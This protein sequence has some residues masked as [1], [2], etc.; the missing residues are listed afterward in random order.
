M[1]KG[2]TSLR[3]GVSCSPEGLT[4][5]IQAAQATIVEES[6]TTH[7]TTGH[8]VERMRSKTNLT[9]SVSLSEKE[10]KEARQR[11]HIIAAQLTVPSSSS[12]RGVQLFNR[13]KQRV[14]AFTLES[15]GVRSKEDVTGNVKPNPSC[16]KLTWAERSREEKDKDL[17]YKNCTTNPLFVPIGST[18]ATGDSMEEQGDCYV[19]EDVAEHNTIQER[20]FLPVKEIDEQEEEQKDAVYKELEGKVKDELPPERE[21]T[22]PIAMNLLE[23]EAAINVGHISSPPLEKLSNGC[24]G[25]PITG[26]SASKQTT[27]INRTA[28]PF[29]SPLT[30]QSQEADSPVLDNLPTRFAF[31]APQPV[32][33]SPPP[34]P[35]YPTPP[36]P[37]FTNKPPKTDYFSPRVTTP[38][39]PPPTPAFTVSQN[40]ATPLPRYGPPTAPKPSA[41]VPQP[42]PERKS[43]PPIKTGLLEDFA[44]KRP[45]KKSMF[46]FKEKKV[47][48]PNPEL[49]SLVQGVDEM[50]NHRQRSVP[51]SASEEELLALGAEA[52]NFLA[53]EEERAEEAN[54][55]E[56]TSCLKS[57]RTYTRVELKPEQTLG[58]ASGKGADLFAKR[59]SRME[60]FIVEN[61][62]AGQHIRPPSPTMSLPPSWVYPSN[63]PGRVKAIAK[64]SDMCAQLA[65]NM[66]AQQTARSKP[67]QAAPAA[68]VQETL[69]LENG[70]S[71]TEM[72]LSRH[73]PYQLN[74]SLFILKPVKDPLNTLPKGA[75]QSKNEFLPPSLSRQAS[76]PNNPASLFSTQSQSPQFPGSSI[77]RV[78]YPSKPAGGKPSTAFSPT[79]VSSPRLGI[80]APKPR[81][82]AKKAGLEAQKPKE[83]SPTEPPSETRLGPTRKYS[84]PDCL[85]TTWMSGLQTKSPS[86][87]V[88]SRSVASPIP[89]ST[90]ARCQS[91]M[92]NQGIQL[93][94]VSLAS[95][96]EPPQTS[97]STSPSSPPWGSR[98]HSPMVSQNIQSSAN[99]SSHDFRFQTS[100][101]S[102]SLPWGSRCQSP[103]VH[104]QSSNALH[105]SSK[106]S[107]N[108]SPLSPPWGSRC[109]SPM[110]SVSAENSTLPSL[111]SSR[112]FQTSATA[113]H[114]SPP[115]S[116]RCQSPMVIQ[117]IHPS[118]ISTSTLSKTSTS[119]SLVSPPWRSRSQS[120]ALSHTSLSFPSANRL[121]ISSASFPVSRPKDSRC[122][123]PISNN[124]DSKANH[125]MLAKNIINAAKRK[126]SPSPGALGGH[127][128]PISPVGYAL[129]GYN[130][131]PVQSQPLGVQSPTFTSPPPTPT[132]RI[133]SPVRLYN[134][135]SLT[136]SDASIESEDSGLR[137][138]G[139]HSYNTCPRGWSGSLRVK[140]ST[141]STDL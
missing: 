133:C 32:A 84:S 11:S 114:R 117:T 22:N 30:V 58:D 31:T 85:G 103:V 77:T 124:L 44:A 100:N 120:P 74:S 130:C 18:Q 101:S 87:R 86:A 82:S 113:P 7:E 40:A 4:K 47:V 48:A 91:P 61:Q 139:M 21:N 35:A 104:A 8:N 10:L 33:V 140:K 56:W 17:N 129:H 3:R 79:H 105:I 34:P 98:C 54:A 50:K 6:N 108:T 41:F 109:Q 121:S 43:V 5:P 78:D 92:S 16:G 14:S 131:K 138:P 136:D 88:S 107:T 71:K 65:L 64:N 127:S 111:S 12:S 72:D 73:R 122:M 45:T 70:C 1:E 99:S 55:P 52:S 123:S 53:K 68:Q 19:K 97:T 94:T 90:V 38:T 15:G 46:T 137:S 25:Q 36:L 95:V 135:R 106:A 57:S 39:N 75:P 59:K 93:S 27:I 49:L 89:F 102:R 83:P 81:F 141:I 69:T 126:N 24:H 118:T 116:P 67:R 13:R 20:H 115:W 76:L 29:F 37:A 42:F 125:R 134:T 60:K 9:R 62:N 96:T 132:Q 66:K 63:M 110:V 128:L 112:P 28:R 119:T 2:H 23:K 51:E 26:V 80:Q